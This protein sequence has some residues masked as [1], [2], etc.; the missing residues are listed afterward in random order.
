MTDTSADRPRTD[1]V[2][3]ALRVAEGAKQDDLDLR[4]LGGGAI[5]LRAKDDFNPAFEREYGT[6]LQRLKPDTVH[7]HH[8]L[9]VGIEALLCVRGCGCGLGGRNERAELGGDEEQPGK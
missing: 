9:G 5:K 3:E 7:F 2:E 1:V 6:L 8:Y 4:L